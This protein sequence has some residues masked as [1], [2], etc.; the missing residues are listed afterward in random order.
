MKLLK[1]FAVFFF[2]CLCGLFIALAGGIQWGT[3]DAA[4]VALMSIFFGGIFGGVVIEV[5]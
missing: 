4:G 3:H 1:F 2:V 5:A